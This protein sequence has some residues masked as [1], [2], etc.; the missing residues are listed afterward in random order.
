MREQQHKTE[1]DSSKT[2]SPSLTVAERKKQAWGVDEQGERRIGTKARKGHQDG[3]HPFGTVTALDRWFVNKILE[4]ADHPPVNISLWDGKQINQA[5]QPVA[6]LR[7]NDRL[8]IWKL[9]L[10]PELHFG[11]LYS[12]GRISFEGDMV[13][14]LEEVYSGLKR[15][16][17]QGWFRKL[18]NWLGHRRIANS[19]SRA[20]DNIYHH[21]D[22]S[23]EFYRLWLDRVAMQYTC[24][25]FPDPEMSLEDSQ[26]AKLHHVCRK[27]QLKPGDRVVE[28]GCGWGGLARF[29]AKHYGVTVKAYNISREQ[30]RFAREQ[31]E[32][33]GLSDKVEYVE[34]DYRNIRGSYDVFV[35]V[36]M[37]EHVGTRDYSELGRVIDRCL[38]PDGRGLIHTI[39]RNVAGPMN[40]WIE[41]RIFPG[42]YPPSLREMMDIFEPCRFSVQDVENLRLHYART[43]EHWLA[44][45]EENVETVREM[46][47]EEFVR[48]WRLYLCGSI[49]AFTSGELQLFQVVFTRAQHNQLPWSRTYL[50]TQDAG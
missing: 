25:Y 6:S 22:L 45:Y 3:S 19:L 24:S 40:P 16:G 12:A 18:V 46:F 38:E 21:Y 30:V 37:L 1:P 39:G 28:A 11:D 41:R 20:R 26:T 14:F 34:D 31:A 43:L 7:F 10:H 17:K 4:V 8:A 2:S 47:D 44:R 15:N 49:A 48:A 42:A 35:S 27:L 32:E 50:Y 29:M 36:G 9:V 23:N 33:Q 13:R 5:E